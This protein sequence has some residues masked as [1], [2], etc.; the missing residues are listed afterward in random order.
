MTF[1]FAQ[2][3]IFANTLLQI[4]CGVKKL[5]LNLWLTT[6]HDGITPLKCYLPVL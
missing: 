5:V 2:D 4:D 6:H 3:V 1:N